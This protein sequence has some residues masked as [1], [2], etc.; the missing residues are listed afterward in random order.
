MEK[1]KDKVFQLLE[2][3]CPGKYLLI[4]EQNLSELVGS[5]LSPQLSVP[6]PITISFL[7]KYYRFVIRDL[8]RKELARQ[9]SITPN[10]ISDIEKG[11]IKPQ[12]KT[13]KKLGNAL[14]GD[15]LTLANLIY[16]SET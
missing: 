8:T 6:D 3:S 14:G 7:L 12:P 2:I 9:T 16:G 15:F 10:Q 11:K 5:G 13:I 4:R 1:M